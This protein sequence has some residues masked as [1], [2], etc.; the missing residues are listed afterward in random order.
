MSRLLGLSNLQLLKREIIPLISATLIVNIVF[1]FCNVIF[2]ESAL[3]YLGLG[4]GNNYP[5]WGTMIEAGQEYLN[6]A[7]WMSFWPGVM[8]VLTLLSADSLG[9][10]INRNY[11]PGIV[12]DKR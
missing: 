1:Q 9:R 3:S 5:S 12:D 4:V 11:N 6:R 8:L 10:E 7:W 2:A